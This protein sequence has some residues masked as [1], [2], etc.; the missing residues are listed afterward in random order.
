MSVAR[1]VLTAL[2]SQAQDPVRLLSAASAQ[3]GNKIGVMSSF[4][5]ESALLLA[6]V[7]EVDPDMPVL[8]LETGKHFPETLTYRAEL[9]RFLGL[10][11][12]IDI[13][14]AQA[15][16]QE[17][18]PTG[19]LWAFDPDACCRLRKVEPLDLATLPY[20]A[21]VT[22]RKRSQATTRAALPVVEEKAD[23]QLRLNPLALW[24][25]EDITREIARRGLPPHP[26]VAEG[27]PS[28]GCAPCTRPVGQTSDQRAGRWVGLAKTEC[29]IHTAS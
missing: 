6:F 12:V 16:V 27:Y 22:G 25:A 23:S 17:R 4:G 7:A 2:R 1:S 21:L 10:K 14:P 19:E 3:F 13:R 24:Q 20:E 9:A 8:F 5:A 26:L 15:E 29:G 18:D 11:N 28:I